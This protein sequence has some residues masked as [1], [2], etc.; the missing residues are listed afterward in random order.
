MDSTRRARYL[1]PMCNLYGLTKGLYAWI[2]VQPEPCP[3]AIRRL[4][5]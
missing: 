3:D 4:I 5:E 1:H 2:V